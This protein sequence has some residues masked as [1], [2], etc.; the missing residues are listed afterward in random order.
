LLP[1]W[2]DV[3]VARLGAAPAVGATSAT[4]RVTPAAVPR[5]AIFLD[6]DPVILTVPPGKRRDTP[7]WRADTVRTAASDY[8]DQVGEATPDARSL[9]GWGKR[10]QEAI[11]H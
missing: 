11:T 9:V 5:S 2:A 8:T 1:D 3:A 10:P 4:A 7:R 6:V